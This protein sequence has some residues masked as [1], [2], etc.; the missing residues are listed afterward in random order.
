VLRRIEY[1]LYTRDNYT[2]P[3]GA[4]WTDFMAGK[5]DVSQPPPAQLDIAKRMQGAADQEKPLL[6]TAFLTPNWRIAPFDDVRVRQAFSLAIDRQALA[7]DNS[8]TTWPPST[9]PRLPT[10]H[11]MIEGLPGYNPALRDP[12]GRSGQPALTA[13]L[14]TA[15]ALV[16]DYAA[17]KCDGQLNHCSTIVAFG[18]TPDI[19][20]F[21]AAL[22]KQ[23]QA[24]FPGWPIT[25]TGC[26][27]GCP[28]GGVNPGFVQLTYGGW[29]ADYPDG[30]G[31]L[32]LLWRTGAT[33]NRTGVSIPT[34]DVL[35]D[36][37]DASNDQSQRIA[38]YQQ[39]EQLLVNQVSAIPLF[40]SEAVYVVRTKVVNWRVAPTGQTPLS[41]WQTTYLSR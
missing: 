14:R 25:A 9:I 18:E 20:P 1:T 28:D 16:A 30:Q 32:S 24:A 11:L 41:V 5:G 6:A 27:R 3:S 2:D 17:E 38:L 29:G 26:G 21:Q 13:D 22:V 19:T 10:T 15:R 12:A 40:Q 34:A 36:Q 39:A 8:L 35:L 37:A 7:S 23:W 33:Y 4:A 31:Y